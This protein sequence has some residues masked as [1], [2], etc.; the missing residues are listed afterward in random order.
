MPDCLSFVIRTKRIAWLMSLFLS[1]SSPVIIGLVENFLIDKAVVSP[2]TNKAVFL[3]TL[4]LLKKLSAAL[5]LKNI[6]ASYFLLMLTGASEV[7]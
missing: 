5:G 3:G 7:L 4:F 2:I 6:T 1:G